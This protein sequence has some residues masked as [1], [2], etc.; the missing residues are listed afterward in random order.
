ML[1]ELKIVYS[2]WY[3]MKRSKNSKIGSEVI[4]WIGPWI[5]LVRYPVLVYGSA[6]SAAS[7]REL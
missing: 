4:H 2:S 5:R 6:G 1:F 3:H 7:E